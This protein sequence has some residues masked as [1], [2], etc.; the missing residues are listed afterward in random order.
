MR[1]DIA[2]ENWEGVLETCKQ[3]PEYAY[4]IV[5]GRDE[6][7]FDQGEWAQI[8]ELAM[9]VDNLCFKLLCEGHFDRCG[10]DFFGGYCVGMKNRALLA[11]M[12]TANHCCTLLLKGIVTRDHTAYDVCCLRVFKSAA[13]TN[14][15]FA[16]AKRLIAADITHFENI[17][18]SDIYDVS[19]SPNG[20]NKLFSLVRNG[21][22][23][24][25]HPHFSR[26][27]MNE[28]VLRSPTIRSRNATALLKSNLISPRSKLYRQ[29]QAATLDHSAIRSRLLG[30]GKVGIRTKEALAEL[31]ADDFEHGYATAYRSEGQQFAS[32]SNV[33]K[34]ILDNEKN[35]SPNLQRA[36][37]ENHFRAIQAH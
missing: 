15:G 9:H 21:I 3:N 29:L 31:M 35:D 19:R 2:P 26:I 30:E 7:D 20:Q 33:I 28:I 5:T 34:D 11:A 10:E 16:N 22:I 12:K 6:N 14:A 24:S 36:V 23:N 18:Y 17:K 13:K 25:K 1:K 37:Q 8:T 27:V 32:G 4:Q